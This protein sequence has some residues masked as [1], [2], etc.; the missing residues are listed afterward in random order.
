MNKDYIQNL[1]YKL[2][3]R[4]RKLNSAD[5]QVFHFAVKQFWGFLNSH[6]VLKGILD[7]LELRTRHTEAVANQA[8]NEKKA[9][10]IFNSE[11]ENVGLSYFFLKKCAA[12]TNQFFEITLAHKY[13]S[14]SPKH[15]D[16]LDYFKQLF[17]EALYDYIDEQLDDQKAILAQLRRYKHKCEWFQRNRLFSMWEENTAKGEKLLALHLYDYLHDQG[18]DF[19]IEPSSISGEVDLVAAQKSNDPLVADVKI[20]NPEK[21]KG[22]SY[23]AKGFH[24][25]YQYTLD[26]NEP[27]GY[28]II[29][30]TCEQDLKFSLANKE[31]DTLLILHNNKSIFLIT[32]DV[33]P[34]NTSASKRGTLRTVEINESDFVKVAEQGL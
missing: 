7:D 13:Y 20:F 17:L 31:Q 34:H 25:I 15:D 6:T 21:S 4:V 27:F 24:R 28:L 14:D 8:I 3:K 33:F 23:L 16:A 22:A 26:Y 1:R 19:V 11:L 10:P 12:S 32:I 9:S 30:K 18:I 2:Q 29:F 5:Y